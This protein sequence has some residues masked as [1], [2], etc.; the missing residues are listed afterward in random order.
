MFT[1]ADVTSCY[2]LDWDNCPESVKYRAFIH[3]YI[4]M[5]MYMIVKFI[6]DTFI[7]RMLQLVWLKT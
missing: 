6:L 5:H 4:F 2:G 7:L 3:L 1:I